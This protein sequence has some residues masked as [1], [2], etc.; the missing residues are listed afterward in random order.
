ML[1]MNSL[2][3]FHSRFT[4][5]PDT[6][7]TH[8]FP[9]G[10]VLQLNKSRPALPGSHSSMIR[11]AETGLQ[12]QVG[13]RHQE[14][15]LQQRGPRGGKDDTHSRTALR[16]PLP[17]IIQVLRSR[18]VSYSFPSIS[19]Y[20][21]GHQIQV[22]IQCLIY[23]VNQ[24]FESHSNS[25]IYFSCFNTCTIWCGGEG[26]FTSIFIGNVSLFYDL[27]SFLPSYIMFCIRP[28]FIT[29]IKHLRYVVLYTYIKKK[30]Y[31]VQGFRG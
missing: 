8:M 5:F 13:D 11:G 27:V 17:S 22:F 20:D 12:Q 7:T 25:Q 31:S 28:F 4:V 3:L 19:S 2:G 26:I 16:K 15:G 9:S 24:M 29:V 18:A 23:D 6:Q 1:T 21:T 10:N 14:R 30:V